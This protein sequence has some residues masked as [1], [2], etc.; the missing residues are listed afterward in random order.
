MSFRNGCVRFLTVSLMA[1]VAVIGTGCATDRAVIGQANQMH[2]GIK[3]AVI[4]DPELTHYLQDIGDRIIEAAREYERQGGGPE[5][6]R[7][8]KSDWMFGKDMKFHLVNSKTMNAF[9]TG[10]NHMY[11]YNEL[12]QQAESED[13]LAAVMAHEFAHVYGRHVHKGMNRQLGTM[14]AAGGAGAAG[15]AAG[16]K[17]KGQTYA[18]TFAGAALVAGQFI[19]MGYTRKDEDE[20]DQLGFIFY[21]RAGWD[22][23]HFADF[24][25][26]MID[27]GYDKTPEMLSDHPTLASRVEK[28]KHRTKRLPKNADRWRREPIADQREFKRLQQRAAEIGRK[29]PDD[30][31]LEKAQLLLAAFPS[32]V[33]PEDQPEQQEAQEEL[34]RTIQQQKAK[35]RS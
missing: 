17:E 15:Y 5:A 12:F 34:A 3:P 10:G 13:E 28:T 27:K 19:G 31:T 23:D 18:A 20:A 22:P 33:T 6:H 32:C 11:I 29:V 1:V 26:K 21:T 30:Q 24:F 2:S 8:E 35:K 4:D 9:T 16:G 7:K 25:Q 14:L